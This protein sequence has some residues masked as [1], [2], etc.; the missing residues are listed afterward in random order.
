M[1][2]GGPRRAKGFP[3]V[4]MMYHALDLGL[5]VDDFWNSTPRMI[6]LLQKELGK[7]VARAEGG[8]K[9]T[10]SGTRITGGAMPLNML[11]RP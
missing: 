10:A 3:W 11:P 1:S 4:W 7:S 2:H 6:I 5:S 8:R 9:T